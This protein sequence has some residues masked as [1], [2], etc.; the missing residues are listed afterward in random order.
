MDRTEWE[1]ALRH[2]EKVTADAERYDR[3]V[4]LPLSDKLNRIEDAAGLDRAR[5]G[6]WDRRKAF[7]DVN[8]KLYHDYSVVSD[9]VDR[10]G[11]AVAD[12]LGVAMDTPAPDLAAL[13]WKLEQ[14]REG[15][16]DLSPW[17]AGFVRQTFED[18]ERLLPPPS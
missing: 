8:P 15:D 10:R 4:W 7:M 5:F 11:D 6:F 16:G 9:E 3:E 1:R 13:R 18:V 14:L 17:T 2:F 12:A